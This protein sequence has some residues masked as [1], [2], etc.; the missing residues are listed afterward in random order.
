MSDFA[1][2]LDQM[3]NEVGHK[4]KPKKIA[5]ATIIEEEIEEVIEED[6]VEPEPEYISHEEAEDESEIVERILTFT[7]IIMKSIR[8]NF[9][10]KSQKQMAYD[11]VSNAINMATGRKSTSVTA[12][13]PPPVE[14]TVI[15][16]SVTTGKSIYDFEEGQQVNLNQA[17]VPENITDI[18]TQDINKVKADKP[19]I[20]EGKDYNSKMDIQMK[21]GRDGKPEVDMASMSQQD[22]ADMRVIAGIV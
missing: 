19:I 17:Y 22:M 18:E 15:P 6:Y 10:N 5:P 12:I 9:P 13:I 7:S 8:E 21:I 16:P 20:T 2:F 11:S 14:K 1:S 4:P 3:D